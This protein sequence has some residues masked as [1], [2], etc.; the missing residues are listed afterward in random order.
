[1][2]F[3]DHTGTLQRRDRLVTEPFHGPTDVQLVDSR[4]MDRL[5]C[6][7]PWHFLREYQVLTTIAV[8]EHQGDFYLQPDAAQAEAYI[9]QPSSPKSLVLEPV[10][11]L[12]FAMVHWFT[13]ET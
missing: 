10:F 5:C 3:F 8:Y 11:Y 12:E 4:K 13:Q 1:M 6:L 9:G 2:S 7:C